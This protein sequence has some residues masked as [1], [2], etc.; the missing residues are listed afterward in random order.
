MNINP[1]NLND[2]NSISQN[3]CLKSNL[4]TLD[5][6]C[7]NDNLYLVF[8]KDDIQHLERCLNYKFIDNDGVFFWYGR[9]LGT[10]IEK[11]HWLNMKNY[12]EHLKYLYESKTTYQI[13]WNV[14]RV[15]KTKNFILIDDF[16]KVDQKF[17][18][19][20]IYQKNYAC[21]ELK[22]ITKTLK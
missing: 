20:I 15:Y 12:D 18:E 4:K 2:L 21:Y 10:Y 17:L 5:I 6:I 7:A 13:D 14:Q 8:L 22:H 3:N 1:I 11:V 9:K 19:T 16:K